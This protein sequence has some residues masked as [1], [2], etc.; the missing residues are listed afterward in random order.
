[1]N[2]NFSIES[3]YDLFLNYPRKRK[4]SDIYEQDYCN[5]LEIYNQL[6]ND[7]KF[8]NYEYQINFSKDQYY[9]NYENDN[10]STYDETFNLDDGE[11]IYDFLNRE[12]TN[13]EI[14]TKIIRNAIESEKTFIHKFDINLIPNIK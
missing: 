10:N 12:L 7:L 4:K 3:I 11:I 13:H 14:Y 6:R 5:A 8:T 1:M 9:M 2:I